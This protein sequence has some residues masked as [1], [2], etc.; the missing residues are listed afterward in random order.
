[1]V[2]VKMMLYLVSI[3]IYLQL[4]DK[5]T[6][7]I[8]LTNFIKNVKEGSLKGKYLNQIGENEERKKKDLKKTERKGEE[9]K[10]QKKLKLFKTAVI[11]C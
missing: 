6:S 10:F 4:I 1:M 11:K 7:V 3:Q 5:V 8:T 2:A 9:I